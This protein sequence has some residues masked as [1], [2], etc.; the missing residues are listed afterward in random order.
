MPT[1]MRIMQ[2]NIYQK[3]EEDIT[4]PIKFIGRADLY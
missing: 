4:L 1:K 2:Y 3:T